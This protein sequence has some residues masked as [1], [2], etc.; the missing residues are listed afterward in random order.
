[1]DWTT[2]ER[3]FGPTL[4][5]SVLLALW[6]AGTHLTGAQVHRLAATG[7]ERGVRY[8]LQRLVTHGIVRSWPVGS[9]NVYEL[10]PEHLSF[11]AVDAAFRVLNPW[12]ELAR[13]V[14]TLVTETLPPRL[15]D[16]HLRPPDVTV[17]VFGSVSRG[18]SD[19]SSDLDLL[20]V[21]P[22]DTEGSGHLVDE[23]EVQG[24]RWTGQR[25]QVYLATH[26]ELSR[27]R[28][29]G[30]PVIESFRAD[31]RLIHGASIEHLLRATA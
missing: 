28:D 2:P 6:R 3:V 5:A 12:S 11:P 13:R 18:T 29:A 16:G 27:A 22:D 24:R 10:N 7:S 30:D 1:M 26:S 21:V 4:D 31:A 17:C 9:A 8:A 20:V 15:D 25:V 19:E 14:E 23:L